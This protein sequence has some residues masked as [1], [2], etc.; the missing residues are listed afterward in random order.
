MSNDTTSLRCLGCESAVYR[1]KGHLNGQGPAGFSCCRR[2]P[3]ST[4]SPDR[5]ALEDEW[6]QRL[7]NR[8]L[9]LTFARQYLAEVQSDFPSSGK[10][11][12]ADGAFALSTCAPRRETCFRRV[13][14]RVADL[15][16]PGN[17]RQGSR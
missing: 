10:I 7:K 15:Y 9:Q 13:Q 4:P 11:H 2:S 1:I 3:M 5:R 16:R 14:S 8:E 17:A 6:R 12:G